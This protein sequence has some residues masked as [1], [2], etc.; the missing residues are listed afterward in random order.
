MRFRKLGVVAQHQGV[1]LL[2]KASIKLMK[3]S[4]FRILEKL[5]SYCLMTFVVATIISLGVLQLIVAPMFAAADAAQERLFQERLKYFKII[6]IR[7]YHPNFAPGQC[8]SKLT[9]EDIERNFNIDG[10]Y[11]QIGL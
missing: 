8:Y 2:A 7:R 4:Y 5:S 3:I 6:A 10:M 1:F 9:Y 11:E